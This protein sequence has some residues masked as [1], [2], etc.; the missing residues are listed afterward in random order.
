MRRGR[1]NVYIVILILLIIVL[2]GGYI[3][4]YIQG[5]SLAG[6][7]GAPQVATPV[8]TT[9]PKVRVL[10]ANRTIPADTLLTADLVGQWFTA[11][12]R[13]RTVEMGEDVI[14]SE[15]Q[16]IGYVTLVDIQPG[17]LLHTSQ[18]TPATLAHRIPKGRRAMPLK[19]D[20][21]S[22]VVGKIR[23]GD[24]VDIVFSG[25]LELHYPQAF[26]PSPE[27]PPV[28]L[29]PVSLLAVK[30]ILQDI[31]ILEVVPI[32]SSAAMGPA[33]PQPTPSEGAPGPT[34]MMPSEWILILAV[35]NEEAEVL[36][37]IQD[38]GMSYQ[39][40]LRPTGDH[41]TVAT[42]GVTTKILV[43]TYGV[44]I[45]AHLR[46]EISPGQLPSGIIP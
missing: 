3:W 23:A 29:G 45:P 18:F 26:P 28:Y 39:L 4:L 21:Y 31:Q 11:Q 24:W 8:P 20:P 44:P 12:E 16:L 30:T 13:E 32:T 17:E 41:G 14:G 35:T 5:Q 40:L 37:F 25:Y 6:R 36:R 7:P 34:S 22:G 43:Q 1:R 10:V 42:Q 15:R 33:R 19:V 38:Q 46:Y 2:I 9:V 27:E